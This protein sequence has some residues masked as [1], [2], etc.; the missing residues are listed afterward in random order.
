[1]SSWALEETFACWT[2]CQNQLAPTEGISEEYD[3]ILKCLIRKGL[4]EGIK[5]PMIQFNTEELARFNTCARHCAPLCGVPT[6]AAMG[7]VAW[8]A[9][10]SGGLGALTLTSEI[11]LAADFGAV[12]FAACM[13]WCMGIPKAKKKK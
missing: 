5:E 11:G 2:E 1:M 3:C 8:K 13:G 6:V 7:F 10:V 4:V 9:V 12:C